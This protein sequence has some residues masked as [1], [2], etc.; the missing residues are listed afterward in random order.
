MISVRLDESGT[1]LVCHAFRSLLEELEEASE[2]FTEQLGVR[3]RVSFAIRSVS[4]RNL[5]LNERRSL[6]VPGV[7][8]GDFIKLMRWRPSG[9][10]GAAASL[11]GGMV[12]TPNQI[13]LRVVDPYLLVPRGKYVVCHAFNYTDALFDSD[14]HTQAGLNLTVSFPIQAMRTLDLRGL[15]VRPT[16]GKRL[17]L[18]IPYELENHAVAGDAIV[19]LPASVGHCAGAAMLHRAAVCHFGDAGDVTAASALELP[20]ESADD[21]GGSGVETRLLRLPPGPHV[22][23][24]AFAA[25]LFDGGDNGGLTSMQPGQTAPSPPPPAASERCPSLGAYSAT[26]ALFRTQYGVAL[27]VLYPVTSL[28]PASVE[29]MMASRV[30]I[31]GGAVHDMVRFVPACEHG[32]GRLPFD[33]DFPF[34]TLDA[35]P[36]T[37][38]PPPA[39]PRPPNAPGQP[40]LPAPTAPPYT[41]TVSLP[42]G[43]LP[44]A[45]YKACYAYQEDFIEY[46]DPTTGTSSGVWPVLS[47]SVEVPLVADTTALRVARPRDPTPF[48]LAHNNPAGVEVFPGDWTWLR[49]STHCDEE[50]GVPI[51]GCCRA[52]S[53]RRRWRST[54]LTHESAALS[55]YA[56]ATVLDGRTTADHHPHLASC[57]RRFGRHRRLGGTATRRRRRVFCGARECAV[58]LRWCR[59]RLDWP[60]GRRR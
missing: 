25:D 38:S 20:A 5:L 40:T 3:L 55:F 51:A 9:C 29:W 21:D 17:T 13:L 18:R 37:F 59:R 56:H 16:T 33:P 32:C 1:Y 23:C 10:T 58:L 12:T 15:R 4:P 45:L 24:H 11:D 42:I 22:V 49:L 31:V 2:R 50:M 34:L 39:V 36:A 57:R 53:F 46:V 60:H 43:H 35:D 48:T 30:Q 28:T 41:G 7:R 19:V 27:D 8:P 54:R 44:A 47:R 26:D 6:S 52:R 14:Y